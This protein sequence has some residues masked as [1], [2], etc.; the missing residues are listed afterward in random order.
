MPLPGDA[1]PWADDYAAE[2]PPSPH[3]GGGAW[4]SGF[5]LGLLGLG[6]LAAALVVGLLLLSGAP[7]RAVL[8]VGVDERPDE[9]ALGI[10]GHTDTI[11]TLVLEPPGGATLISFPR[12]LWVTIPGYGEQR[13]NVAYPLGAQ[14]GRPGDGAKLLERTITA[15][16][17]LP[18]DR[19]ARVDFRGFAAL[20]DALGGVD[21][22][23]P[24]TLVDDTY[25]T[26]DYGTR[27]L[28]IPAGRQHMDGETA[29][30]YVRTRK[31]DSDFGRVGRQQQLLAALR[32]QA[33]TPAGLLR[34]P[35]ALL[36]LPGA[37][38]SDLSHRE[39]LALLRTLAT[40]RRDRLHPLVIGPDLAP[41]ARTA[42]GAD[43]LMPRTEAIR[44]VIANALA[45]R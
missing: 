30:A 12:D 3:G 36:T 21:I 1:E 44:Q 14:S 38:S 29:L 4:L 25:P 16:F 6:A 39:T 5:L 7:P 35:R 28:V 27:R 24:R 40:L 11:A 18:V 13:L 42:G 10:A 23:V 43:V 2:A 33:V 17:G 22:D 32:D 31:A 20:V 45:G 9:Q 8:L 26:E 19:W 34:L 41:P 15:A 37:V